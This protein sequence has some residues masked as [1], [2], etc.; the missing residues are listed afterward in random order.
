MTNV[1]P[2]HQVT[3]PAYGIPR[4]VIHRMGLYVRWAGNIIPGR[5]N[6]R[7]PTHHQHVAQD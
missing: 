6:P 5:H 3:F 4:H 1:L 7:V 2:W